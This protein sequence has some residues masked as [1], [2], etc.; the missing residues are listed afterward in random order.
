MNFYF[1]SFLASVDSFSVMM[2]QKMLVWK[3][4]TK[5]ASD[6]DWLF[7]AP[8]SC[9]LKMWLMSFWPADLWPASL[10]SD[11]SPVFSTPGQSLRPPGV[12]IW[13]SPVQTGSCSMVVLW[14]SPVWS[15]L[16]GVSS[17]PGRD[18]GSS[19]RDHPS[20]VSRGLRNLQCTL[21]KIHGL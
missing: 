3:Q 12:Q 7:R 17:E 18:G 21:G 14:F 11:P 13:T 9:T 20:S 5:E 1:F 4:K 8:D 19:R 2:L 15:A 16:A 6:C 10:T